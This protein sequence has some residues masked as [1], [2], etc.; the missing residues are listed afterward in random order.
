MIIKL[1]HIPFYVLL[2]IIGVAS[3]VSFFLLPV[4]FFVFLIDCLVLVSSSLYGIAGNIQ[5]TKQKQM[6]LGK[7]ILISV[8]YFIFV[9]DLIVAIYMFVFMKNK[10]LTKEILIWKIDNEN[11]MHI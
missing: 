6:T 3:W 1:S 10:L 2:F 4:A 11:R 8:G 5:L 7:A 9:I